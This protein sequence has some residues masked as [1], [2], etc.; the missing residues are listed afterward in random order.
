M[1]GER[2]FLGFGF[3]S[4]LRF[5]SHLGGPPFWSPIRFFIRVEQG[6]TSEFCSF[7]SCFVMPDVLQCP[8]SLVAFFPASVYRSVGSSIVLPELLRSVDKEKLS[9]V[10][11]LCSFDLQG[12]R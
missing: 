1:F 5:L 11:F 3:E 9:A 7:S 10:Q 8:N 6:L 12:C 2:C 4:F